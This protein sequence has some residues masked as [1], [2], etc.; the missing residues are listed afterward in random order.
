MTTHDEGRTAEV[1]SPV[2]FIADADQEARQVTES[3]LLRRFAAD[4]R[5]LSAPTPRDGL[6]RLE[7]MADRSDQMALVAADL[8]LPASNPGTRPNVHV[9]QNVDSE[10]H[11]R[12]PVLEQSSPSATLCAVR[13]LALA[14][15]RSS[16]SSQG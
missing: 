2:L 14:D 11:A 6:D 5:V 10:S 13:R 15:H 16:C 1:D 4:Y 7:R 8:H 3:A 12:S 9:S